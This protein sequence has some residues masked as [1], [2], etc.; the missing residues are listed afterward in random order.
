MKN[1]T[2]KEGYKN[3]HTEPL[4]TEEYYMIIV[5]NDSTG[6]HNEVCLWKPAEPENE[7]Q[8]GFLGTAYCMYSNKR[9]VSTIGHH[10]WEQN[11]A[12]FVYYKQI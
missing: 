12:E 7:D 4:P 1:L 9:G 5:I 10:V 2:L 8:S 6:E 3:R 11:N